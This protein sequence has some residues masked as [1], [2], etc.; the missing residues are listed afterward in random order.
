MAWRDGTL[1]RRM[2]S[3]ILVIVLSREIRLTRT[4]FGR[5]LGVG[6]RNVG[7][8]FRNTQFSEYTNTVFGALRPGGRK[9][10]GFWRSG[11]RIGTRGLERLCGGPPLRRVL[12]CVFGVLA[13]ESEA[14]DPR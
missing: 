14:V 6:R 8:N 5:V 9:G 13:L 7:Y 3:N 2:D 4:A 1:K 12:E 10:R 11:V